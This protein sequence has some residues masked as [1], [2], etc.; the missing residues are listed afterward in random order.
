MESVHSKMILIFRILF[1]QGK[2]IMLTDRLKP[3]SSETYEKEL[4]GFHKAL[5]TGVFLLV[6]LSEDFIGIVHR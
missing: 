6:I 3:S 4:A 5:C 2:A 1:C